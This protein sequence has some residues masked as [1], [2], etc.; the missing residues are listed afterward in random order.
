MVPYMRLLWSNFCIYVFMLLFSY[1]IFIDRQFSDCRSLKIEN[2]NN[3]T[4]TETTAVRVPRVQVYIETSPGWLELPLTGTN[5]H[6]PNLFEQLKFCCIMFAA[7]IH[8]HASNLIFPFLE[9]PHKDS[10]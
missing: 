10:K 4:K 3:N 5:F 2:E 7:N 8:L 1:S 6:G 9:T